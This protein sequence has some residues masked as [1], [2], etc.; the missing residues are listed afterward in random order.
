MKVSDIMIGDWVYDTIIQEN[1]K[2]WSFYFRDKDMAEALE[3]IPLTYEFLEE[4]GEKRSNDLF[5]WCFDKTYIEF[6]PLDGN[7]AIWLDFDNEND[8]VYS[9][10]LMPM[11]TAIHELQHMLKICGIDK[12]IQYESK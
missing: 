9:D 7:V 5:V 10:Y 1:V 11:P 8:G 2:V 6:R 12:E 4:I 3:P